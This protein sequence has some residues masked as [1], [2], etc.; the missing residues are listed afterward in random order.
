MFGLFIVS[1]S[2]LVF[3]VDCE[4][5]WLCLVWLIVLMLLRDLCGVIVFICGFVV[6]YVVLFVVCAF[7]WLCNGCLCLEFVIVLVNFFDLV[8]FLVCLFAWSFLAFGYCCVRL[9]DY[10]G[11]GD[12]LLCFDCCCWLVDCYWFEFGLVL[13][14]VFWWFSCNSVAVLRMIIVLYYGVTLFF[15]M[16]VVG[17]LGWLLGGVCVVDLFVCLFILFKAMLVLCCFGLG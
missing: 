2:S 6:W 16:L 14:W 15:A 17:C 1:L 8:C 10:L 9:I 5:F 7:V 11:L 3:V 4:Y 13:V 12:L